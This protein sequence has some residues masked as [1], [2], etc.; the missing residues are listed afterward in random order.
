[1]L[2]SA[3]RSLQWMLFS[4]VTHDHVVLGAYLPSRW[5][6]PAETRP[7]DL[8]GLQRKVNSRTAILDGRLAARKRH[9]QLL[10][11][12]RQGETLVS[13]PM[14]QLE[15]IR[16]EMVS[17][18]ALLDDIL[19]SQPVSAAPF[20]SITTQGSSGSVP[21][22]S[23]V[24]GSPSTLTDMKTSASAAAT[25][26]SGVSILS[27]LMPEQPILTRY[28]NVPPVTIV[29]GIPTSTSA[30]TLS[31]N[32]IP[33]AKS[34][35][36]SP[37]LYLSSIS[38][39]SASS[40]TSN[41]PSKLSSA[42][43]RQ[44]YQPTAGSTNSTYKFN[45]TASDN[46]AVY[47]GQSGATGMT[48]LTKMCLDPNV[49]IVILA[50]LVTFFGP[51]GYPSINFG[52]ACAGQTPQM[53]AQASGLLD[54]GALASQIARCQSLGK[55]LF[56][57]LG[58]YVS[59]TSFQNDMQATK[60]AETL[61]NL[62]GAGT[63]LDPG[64]RPFGKVKIDGFDIDN[65]NHNTSYYNTFATALRSQ[66]AKDPSKPYYISAAPQCPRPDASIPLGSMQHADFVWVQ[67]YNNGVCNIDQPG[68]EASFAAWSAD[69]A[70]AGR[71]GPKIF[72]GTLGFEGGGTG[73]LPSSR[74]ASVVQGV[75][76][77]PN[78]G[79]VMLWD[80]PEAQFNIDREGR[81]YT[82]IVKAALS[83]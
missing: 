26:R 60:F 62:F 41:V 74:F 36:P 45:A 55:K 64:L 17:S 44:A 43:S 31:I 65:E 83:T 7:L 27:G 13:V 1:M 59:T 42:P 3:S 68:F 8:R 54:C 53:Q 66:Y 75:R 34:L 38:A 49:D 33:T 58:G 23:S 80:G 37:S 46:V 76:R 22:N 10:Q 20:S 50:F 12:P 71:P 47:F 48:N 63:D 30:I 56:L 67:F 32:S 57:S 21:T 39:S 15:H 70:A 51:G 19:K 52:A 79:G 28:N 82:K 78:F 61:W 4:I 35:L 18:E 69:L 11:E 81:N 25:S 72:I 24:G 14:S 5:H 16:E 9:A 29:S 40:P 73:Y 77:R 2:L 6:G